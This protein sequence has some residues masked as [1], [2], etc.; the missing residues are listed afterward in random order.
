MGVFAG[1]IDARNMTL[2]KE[3]KC[4]ECGNE[5]EFFVRDGRVIE[6][7]ICENCPLD[8]QLLGPEFSQ[9]GMKKSQIKQVLT[10]TAESLKNVRNT[11]LNRL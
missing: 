7:S 5:M 4:P 8:F 2:I 3:I 11:A 9:R 6:D 1:C 10:F